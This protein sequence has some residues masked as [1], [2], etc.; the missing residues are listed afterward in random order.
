M[1]ETDERDLA[2]LAR[3]PVWRPLD[4]A[5]FGHWDGWEPMLFALP[6]DGTGTNGHIGNLLGEPEEES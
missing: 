4:C 2:L 6:D 3:F 1:T 5:G